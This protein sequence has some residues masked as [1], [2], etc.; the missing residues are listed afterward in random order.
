MSDTYDEH[1]AE[2]QNAIAK[3]PYCRKCRRAHERRHKAAKNQSGVDG[4]V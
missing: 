2:L 1:Q 4:R 3:V